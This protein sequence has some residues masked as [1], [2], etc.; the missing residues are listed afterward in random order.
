MF[1]K[2]AAAST[3]ILCIPLRTW[4]RSWHGI[5][6]LM[7]ADAAVNETVRSAFEYQGQKC[8]ACSRLYVPQS[9]WPAVRRWASA[10]R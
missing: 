8:S 6:G 1:L 7:R 5:G 10:R 4:V 2:S 9:L 3:S